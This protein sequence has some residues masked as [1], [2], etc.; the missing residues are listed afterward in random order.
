MDHHSPECI[1]TK[2]YSTINQQDL[3]FTKMVLDREGIRYETQMRIFQLTAQLSL[4]AER[5]R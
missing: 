2:V 1:P 4:N 5:S 3:L